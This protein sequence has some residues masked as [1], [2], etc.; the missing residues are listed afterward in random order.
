MIRIFGICLL[1]LVSINARARNY[2]DSTELQAAMFQKY[3]DSVKT[4]LRWQHGTVELAGG[5]AKLNVPQKFKFLNAEQSRFVVEE[6]WGNLPD[7]GI[8]G[9]LFPTDTDPFTQGSYVFII[10]YDAMGYVNDEDAEKIDY[11][12]ILKFMKEDQVE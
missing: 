4:A 2:G 1:F 7:E 8:L 5:I 12:D 9:T 10:S 3:V 11:D 6:L